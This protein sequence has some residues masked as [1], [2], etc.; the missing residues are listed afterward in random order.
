MKGNKPEILEK[1]LV[2]LILFVSIACGR[3][4]GFDLILTARQQRAYTV[5]LLRATVGCPRVSLR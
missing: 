4:T 2:M 3:L 5:E 1:T